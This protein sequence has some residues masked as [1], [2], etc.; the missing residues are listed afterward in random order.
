MAFFP[1]LIIFGYKGVIYYINNDLDFSYG[2][3][4]PFTST[5]FIIFI[6]TEFIY[7]ILTYKDNADATGEAMLLGEYS[8]VI[9]T[10]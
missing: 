4:F 2:N 5:I 10:G 8:G 1:F 3:I 6:V 7:I 9:K